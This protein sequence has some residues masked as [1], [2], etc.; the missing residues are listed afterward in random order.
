MSRANA[1]KKEFADIDNIRIKLENRDE[2]VK[3]L[4]RSLKLKVIDWR[5]LEIPILPCSWERIPLL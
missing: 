5:F 3:E 2:D 4:K 1:V